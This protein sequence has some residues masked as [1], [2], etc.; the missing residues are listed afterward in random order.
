MDSKWFDADGYF[1]G[2][3][4]DACIHDCS[5][6]GGVEQ[7]VDFWL[8]ELRFNVPMV[9]ARAYLEEFGAWNDLDEADQHTLAQRVLWVA[10]CDI[11]ERGEWLGLVH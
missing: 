9:K 5:A 10:C 6:S 4:P 1:V 2:S 11:E 8:D 7:A 3:F